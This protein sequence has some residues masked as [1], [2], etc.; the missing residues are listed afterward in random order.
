MVTW[1]CSCVPLIL[2]RDSSQDEDSVRLFPRKPNVSFPP[3]L[4]FAL[5]VVLTVPSKVEGSFNS[6]VFMKFAE[7]HSLIAHFV[8]WFCWKTW[9]HR[10]EGGHQEGVPFLSSSL[11]VPS[12]WGGDT[13]FPHLTQT[14]D[15][16]TETNLAVF[17][18]SDPD[19]VQLT[20]L[21]CPHTTI[22]HVRCGRPGR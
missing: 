12:Q 19:N 11:I 1:V 3:P 15:T 18:A 20:V 13:F 22:N 21:S 7:V 16:N 8:L 9:K 2:N 4:L 5:S 6:A 17:I 10:Q 14:G